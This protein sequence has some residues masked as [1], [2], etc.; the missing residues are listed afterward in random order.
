LLTP[1]KRAAS[2]LRAVDRRF[3]DDLDDGNLKNL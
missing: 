1:G 3:S 2:G